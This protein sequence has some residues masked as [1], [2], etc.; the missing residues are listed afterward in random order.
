MSPNFKDVALI[1]GVTANDVLNLEE[2]NFWGL[3]RLITQ[4]SDGIIQGHR[5]VDNQA[6]EIVKASNRPFL[7]YHSPDTYIEAYDKFYDKILNL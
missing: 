5:E 3:T 4:Y 7:G 2:S 6:L 1:E